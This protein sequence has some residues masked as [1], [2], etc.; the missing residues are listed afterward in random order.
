MLN[1]Y[2]AIKPRRSFC[3]FPEPS[4]WTVYNDN[5]DTSTYI[6]PY[7]EFVYKDGYWVSVGDDTGYAYIYSSNPCQTWTNFGS[8]SGDHEDITFSSSHFVITGTDISYSTTPS[9]WTSVVS[10]ASR[11]KAIHYNGTY[12]YSS[13]V[14]GY[15]YYKLGPD[16]SGTWTRQDV[17][18]GTSNVEDITYGNGYWVAVG[19]DGKI[20]YINSVSPAGTWTQATTGTTSNL[21]G[22]AFNGSYW[23]AVGIGGTMLYKYGT[24]DGTWSPISGITDD[25]YAVA[26]GCPYWLISGSYASGVHRYARL[27]FI[28]NENPNGTWTDGTSGAELTDFYWQGIYAYNGYWLIG[29]RGNYR[30]CISP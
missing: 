1:K 3:N 21:T 24:P 18:F 23:L 16:A 20:F 10:P 14:H 17:P 8:T 7:G 15:G 28:K 9:G 25:L 11:Q 30:G 27:W 13:G 19:H 29:N 4:G 22:I 26:W 2:A 5:P 12:F 6:N